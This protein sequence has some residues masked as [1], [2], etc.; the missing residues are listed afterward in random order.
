VLSW[1]SEIAQSK[2]LRTG[3]STGYGRRFLA[4]RDTWIGIL[5]LGYADGFRR[6]LAGTEVRV[7]GERCRVIGAV[8][9][10]ATAVQLSRELPPGTPVTIVGHGV[11]LEEHARVANTITYEL[12]SRINTS[13]TRARRVVTDS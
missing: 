10:D 3:E 11:P 2:L 1:T 7:G 6:D 12:T 9:M 8:S 5:P 4:E 13:A